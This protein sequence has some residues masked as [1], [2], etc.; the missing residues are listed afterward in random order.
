M[1]IEVAV[2]C[3]LFQTFTYSSQDAVPPGTR[4]LVPFGRL[5]KIGVVISGTEK[6]NTTRTYEV[7]AISSVLDEEPIYSSNMLD[8]AKWLSHYYFHPLGEVL[9]VMLPAGKTRSLKHV[10][11]LEPNGF[12]LESCESPAL[13]ILPAV[14]GKRKSLLEASLHK[15]LAHLCPDPKTARGILKTWL[16][17]HFVRLEKVSTLRARP[18]M[19]EAKRFDRSELRSKT[20]DERPRLNKWQARAY[21]SIVEEGLKKNNPKPFL[22]FGI[23]GSGKTE[24][25][26]NV[27]AASL[28]MSKEQERQTLVLVPEISLTPQMTQIFAKRFPGKVAVVHS[29]MSNDLRWSELER[30]RTGQADIL[31]GPRSA[32]FGPFRNLKLIIVDE[33]HDH[34]YKQSSGLCYHGRDVAVVRGKMEGATVVLGSATPSMESFYNTAI[35]KFCLLELP[36]RATGQPLPTVR[37]IERQPSSKKAFPIRPTSEWPATEEDEDLFDNAVI[38]ALAENSA[39]G[40]QAIVLVNR[41]GFAYYLYDLTS[42]RTVQCPQCSISLVLHGR[43]RVLKCHY[44]DY[45]TNTEVVQ[46]AYPS[47]EFFAVGYGSQRAEVILQKK[48][49]NAKIV[50]LDSDSITQKDMLPSTLAK[51]RNGEIDILVGTQILAKGHD[52]PKVTLMIILE[53]DQLLAMPDFR[54]A[55]RTFQLLVQAAGRAGRAQLPGE[56]II[57]SMRIHHPVVQEALRQD[58]RNF[59]SRELEYRRALGY[60]P[61]G[62]M[63]LYEF[64][65]PDKEKLAEFCQ[66]IRESLIGFAEENRQLFKT[67]KSLGPST[68][69]IET[70]RGRHRRI[71]ILCS[72]EREKIRLIAAHIHEQLKKLPSRLKVRID[73][74]PQSMM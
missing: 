66:K 59:A 54:G 58:Y 17:D 5:K 49:P 40:Q 25:F 52:F 47:H 39:K 11:Y 26:L 48:L 6:A 51:F 24:V 23:T 28:E 37:E 63:I 69:A 22:L 19:E 43:R 64:T 56:V 53:V 44:C 42:K 29:G 10:Y 65:C 31:I 46:H 7:K 36:E 73:V 12:D 57:Q 60:P 61:F 21:E 50:R 41:R 35:G 20:G 34:S 15:R 45:Q 70:I 38:N 71:L 1:E 74:D 27:I 2:P 18:L 3:P 32:V 8:L 55:E 62:R 67:V 33:E 30:I 72:L 16:A 9:A 68:P 13:K 14:F 4:V